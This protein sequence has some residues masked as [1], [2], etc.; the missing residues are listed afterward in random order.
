MLCPREALEWF[1]ATPARAELLPE[2]L[3]NWRNIQSRKKNEAVQETEPIKKHKQQKP[4][5]EE[6]IVKLVWREVTSLYQ[7][8]KEVGF[9][10]LDIE[11]KLKDQAKNELKTNHTN[12]DYIKSKHLNSKKLFTLN[13]GQEKR[14]FIGQLLQIIVKDNGIKR[15]NYQRLYKIGVKI[16]SNHNQK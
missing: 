12:Y 6:A 16:F 10:G 1:A 3:L 9:G 4:G 2:A 5:E 13:P 7:K 11:S 15:T 8:I 14:D